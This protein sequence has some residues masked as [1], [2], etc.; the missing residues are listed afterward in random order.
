MKAVPSHVRAR[1]R[2][3]PRLARSHVRK[4][5]PGPESTPVVKPAR[6]DATRP[7]NGHSLND[8]M[9]VTLY[10]MLRR[11]AREA[12]RR[13]RSSTHTLQPT[14]L[15][16][17]AYLKLTRRRC[18]WE[19]RNHFLAA[20][21]KAMRCILVDHARTRTRIKRRPRG[22]RISLD[23]ALLE[24]ERK[25]IDVVQLDEALLRLAA[26]DARAARVVEL[27]CFG[28]LRVQDI[29]E[30]LDEP[31][32]TIERDWYFARVWLHAELS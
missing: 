19:S 22:Y 15:V 18:D 17:E 3:P 32:R 5:A 12:M 20:A 26:V 30:I 23:A 2:K 14:A 24:Y 25:R 27:R 8:E 13:P 6:K 11:L 21:A 7:T 10:E 29:A 9:F 16:N 4:A 1:F 28:G 31:K